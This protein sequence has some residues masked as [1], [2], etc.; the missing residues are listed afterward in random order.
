MGFTLFRKKRHAMSDTAWQSVKTFHAEIR[1]IALVKHGTILTTATNRRHY[2]GIS[3]TDWMA[4]QVYELFEDVREKAG[5]QDLDALGPEHRHILL[6][7]TLA[8]KGTQAEFDSALKHDRSV[9]SEHMRGL[10]D[11]WAWARS[12]P[13]PRALPGES[14]AE[15]LARFNRGL[16]LDEAYNRGR[17]TLISGRFID[18]DT[19]LFLLPYA[20]QRLQAL[21]AQIPCVWRNAPAFKNLHMAE[22]KAVGLMYRTLCISD[23]VLELMNEVLEEPPNGDVVME[24]IKMFHNGA[25]RLALADSVTADLPTGRPDSVHDMQLTAFD[26]G[27]RLLDAAMRYYAARNDV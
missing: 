3:E 7:A 19:Q 27:L 2:P 23:D 21:G 12:M 24:C 16:T 15:M 9:M 13:A 11:G 10:R 6:M 18:N 25:T 8:A 17:E 26:T 14:A 5:A 4:V 20:V 22:R 1:T